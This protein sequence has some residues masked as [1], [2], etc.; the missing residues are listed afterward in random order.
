M[1]HSSSP[2]IPVLPQQ[3]LNLFK[4]IAE[5]I[6]V[7]CTVGFGGH[8][9]ELLKQ[10]PNINIIGIDKDEQAREFSKERLEVFKDRFTCVAGSFGQKFGQIL[11]DKGEKIKGVLADI[12]V[13]SVQLDDRTRG[14]GFHSN[15]LDMRMDKNNSL[16]A[17]TIINTYSTYELERIFKEYGEIK[18]Y[19]KMASLIV[20]RRLKE[21]F[22]SGEDL[23]TFLQ[24]HFKNHRIHPA[25]LAF[26]AIRIEVNN[27]LGE[28][29]ELLEHASTLKS[30]IFAI[31]SF[32]SLEDR[33]VKNA[34]KEWSKSCICDPNTYKCE[35]G[36][37]H[38]K[39]S[40]ITKK[41]LVASNDENKQ[42]PR[43]R[44]AKLR[45][46]AFKG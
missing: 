5:G 35:C 27:E 32:H 11:Q 17:S 1:S 37:N 25:T 38:S 23:S 18:E 46:F 6:I 2:H 20:S 24:K 36:N 22:I 33:M 39:G 43:A 41:P 30:T 29:G 16:D 7:D 15:N 42:N 12:G 40:I 45:A 21:P 14:F 31:I 44:S 28:L 19:K 3:V 26:Q 34:F 10:N 9:Y 4:D 13:S 8:S